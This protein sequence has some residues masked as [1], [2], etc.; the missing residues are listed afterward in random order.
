MMT[1]FLILQKIAIEEM[2]E[3]QPCRD[4]KGKACLILQRIAVEKMG[5]ES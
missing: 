2:R 5:E 4:Y 1:E 3:E